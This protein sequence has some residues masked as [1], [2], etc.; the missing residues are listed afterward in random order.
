MPLISKIVLKKYPESLPSQEDF[1]CQ[2]IELQELSDGQ[3]LVKTLYLSVDP[4]MRGLLNPTGIDGNYPFFRLGET[5][6]SGGVGEVLSSK[7]PNFE[8]GDLIEG[9][10]PWQTRFIA[11]KFVERLPWL[12]RGDRNGI[13][14]LTYAHDHPSDAVG[15]YGMPGLTAYFGIRTGE[16]HEGDIVV[17][18]SAAGAVGS[19]AGQLAKCKGATVIGLTSS[20]EKGQKLI[21]ELGFDHAINYRDQDFQDQ[22]TKIAPHG[23]DV[24]I[25]NVGGFVSETIMN[26]LKP[27]KGRVVLLGM[28]STYNDNQKTGHLNVWPINLKSTTMKGSM[29]YHFED[30]FPSA[31][32]E[33]I[34]L[35]NQNRLRMVE[36]AYSG[37]ESAPTALNSLFGNSNFGKVVITLSPSG[38]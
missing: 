26:Q 4:Y 38:S 37:L 30:D 19:V 13:R 15:L 25:D 16:V 27:L 36:R 28:I 32:E 29:F 21:A 7:N 8:E 33:M 20:V 11:D 3:I 6:V 22:I 17:V 31:I 24:Y 35:K 10:L 18:S 1:E 12:G 34:E 23:V 9:A 5:I 14:K 2:E